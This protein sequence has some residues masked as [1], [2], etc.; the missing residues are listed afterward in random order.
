MK[1]IA[2]MAIILVIVS[3]ACTFLLSN[4]DNKGGDSP[5]SNLPV[6]RTR[7]AIV[8]SKTAATICVDVIKIVSDF[9]EAGV[10]INGVKTKLTPVNSS[11]F[12]VRVINLL[13]NTTYTVKAYAIV[14]EGTAYGNELNFTTSAW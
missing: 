6:L 10:I 14:P 9:T 12:T 1:K 13:P 4:C 3:L 2:K 7:E 5:V 11:N 8:I